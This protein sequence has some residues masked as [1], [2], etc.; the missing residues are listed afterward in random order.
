[1]NKKMLLGWIFLVVALCTFVYGLYLLLEPLATSEYTQYTVVRTETAFTPP[2]LV[3]P[4]GAT[5]T[6]TSSQGLPYWPA[7]DL[8]P[9]HGIFSEF[10]PKRALF[11]NESWSFTFE[12]PGQW[13]YHDHLASHIGGAIFVVRSP[14]DSVGIEC[15]TASDEARCWNQLLAKEVSQN[16]LHAA[17]LLLERL[18]DQNTSFAAQ[19]HDLTHDIGVKAYARYKHEVPIL[20]ESRYCNAGFYHGFMEGLLNDVFLPEEGVVFCEKV[21][22]TLNATYP[23]AE[24]Q[25]RH[26]IGHGALEN[27]IRLN[28][29]KWSDPRLSARCRNTNM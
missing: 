24:D 8:H 18:Y 23:A 9:S 25:C 29:H 11:A 19:C 17:F 6:F 22:K 27:I 15:D 1:M 13:L 3:I 26:G 2:L 12:K 28:S 21:G 4:L 20:P 10:D 5:V 14:L 7:S 16:G